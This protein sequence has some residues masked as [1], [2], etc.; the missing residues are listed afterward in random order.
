MKID[1]LGTK[2]TIKEV[3]N[4]GAEHGLGAMAPE[5]RE[6]LIRKDQG[7]HYRSTLIHEI[8][9][10]FL[11]ESGSYLWRNEDITDYLTVM[12]PKMA[13]AI[14]KVLEKGVGYV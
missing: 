13:I 7:D 8:I 14:N 12:V 3:N 11:Y 1:I 6:I 9:H 4:V 2:Y 10:A 5:D